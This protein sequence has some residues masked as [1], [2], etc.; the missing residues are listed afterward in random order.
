MVKPP[1]FYEE[2]MNDLKVLGKGDVSVLLKWRAKIR[3][4]LDKKS[5]KPEKKSKASK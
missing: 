3:Q 5:V 2:L 4:Q 1:P